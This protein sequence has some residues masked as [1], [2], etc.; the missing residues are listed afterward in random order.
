MATIST[1]HSIGLWHTKDKEEN[2]L[3]LAEKNN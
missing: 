2:N 1:L 3:N